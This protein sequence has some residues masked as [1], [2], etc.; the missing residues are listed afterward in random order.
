MHKLA[1]IFALGT[2]G[3]MACNSNINTNT[4][5][6]QD[7]TNATIADT[8]L[9]GMN[10]TA[11]VNDSV[12]A[13]ALPSTRQI[14]TSDAPIAALAGATALKLDKMVGI[15]DFIQGCTDGSAESEADL[16]K[17]QFIFVS[18]GQFVGMLQVNG[19]RVFLRA[20]LSHD[21][22]EGQDVWYKGHGFVVHLTIAHQQTHAATDTFTYD[23][24]LEVMKDGKSISKKKIWG[25]GAC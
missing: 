24:T 1:F 2:L 6:Q 15:P 8:A 21:S 5:Q 13:N 19:V 22:K 12:A 25:G 23:G 4:A 18:D 17:E 10:K 7:T 11:S 16:D 14:D 9:A 3:V 20:D